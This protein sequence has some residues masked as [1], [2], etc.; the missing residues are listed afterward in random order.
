MCTRAVARGGARGGARV[1]ARGGRAKRWIIKL[2][3]W[4]VLQKWSAT[5][6]PVF[7]FGLLLGSCLNTSQALMDI[8]LRV[9]TVQEHM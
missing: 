4:W 9:K 1:G 8:V 6:L 2:R 5:F 7:V 3:V